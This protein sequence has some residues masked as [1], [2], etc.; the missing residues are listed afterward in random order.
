MFLIVACI[1]NV[2][3]YSGDVVEEHFKDA[4]L[5]H[6]HMV[7]TE[8]SQVP[9]SG[10]I[11]LL[12]MAKEAGATTVVDFDVCP[13]VAMNEAQ[14]G[15]LKQLTEVLQ[16][17]DVLKPAKH[18]AKDY[19]AL[20]RPDLKK[21]L[22]SEETIRL[23]QEISGSKMVAMTDGGH[24]TLIATANHLVA[25]P[26]RCIDNVVDA[27]GAGDA[28]LGG[29]I[30]GLYHCEGIPTTEDELRALGEL[31]NSI[32]AAGC[33]VLGALPEESSRQYPSEKL[34]IVGCGSCSGLHSSP[35]SKQTETFEHR[36]EY[37]GIQQYLEPY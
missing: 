22:S 8:I 7:T 4:V 3:F 11:Q 34:G 13:S 2:V 23:L 35:T 5:N 25:I 12:K 33:L 28:F 26:A 6:A 36:E 37:Q 27:T 1:S 17:T 19:I 30:A 15:D 31:A 10:V 20:L 16:L 32:G 29:I 21:A 14:L 18:A 9:L 24:K